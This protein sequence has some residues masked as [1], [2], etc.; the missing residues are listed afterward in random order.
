[1]AQ[2][3]GLLVKRG[4]ELSFLPAASVRCLAPSSR[5]SQIPWDT[6][7]M[8]LVGGEVVPVLELGD[9]TGVLVLCEV[10]GQTVAL[11]GLAPE[12]VGFWTETEQGVSVH[13]VN[14]PLLD[15]DAALTQFRHQLQPSKESPA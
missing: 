14:V 6:A 15:L 2:R 11:S 13:G 8:A 12:Q 3:A 7:R 5:L 9:A 1:M 10:R 4:T